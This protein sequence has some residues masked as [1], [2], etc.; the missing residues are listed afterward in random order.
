MED[1]E[2]EPAVLGV[3]EVEKGEITWP[4]FS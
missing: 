3:E 4:S 2:E 1:E